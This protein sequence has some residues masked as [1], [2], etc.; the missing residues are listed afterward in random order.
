VIRRCAVFCKCSHIYEYAALSETPHALADGPMLV[1]QH[2]V[3]DKRP[4]LK[5]NF[6]MAMAESQIFAVR[7]RL[8]RGPI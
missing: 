8:C 6:I 3:K 7:I 2:P 4:F 5:E 1:F